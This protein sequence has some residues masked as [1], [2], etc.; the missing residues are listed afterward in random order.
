MKKQYIIISLT[1]FISAC[2]VTPIKINLPKTEGDFSLC[3]HALIK[4]YPDISKYQTPLRYS[5]FFEQ[6]LELPEIKKSLGEPNN[7]RLSWWN[8]SSFILG[9]LFFYS[10]G[11]GTALIFEGAAM[12]GLVATGLRPVLVKKWSKGNYIVEATT[13]HSYHDL[14]KGRVDSLKWSEINKKECDN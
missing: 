5:T 10:F 2:A 9:G 1:L 7:S 11:A 6:P 12:V 3:E 13:T 4:K 8:S 14:Y